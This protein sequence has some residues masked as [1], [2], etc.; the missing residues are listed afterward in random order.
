VRSYNDSIVVDNGILYS[1]SANLLGSQLIKQNIFR[2]Y[3][4]YGNYTIA[5][6][7]SAPLAVSIVENGVVVYTTSGSTISYRSTLTEN[8]PLSVTVQNAETSVTTYDVTI[9]FPNVTV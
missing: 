9:D 4:L 5:I 1:C 2:S 7:A 6:N 8:E 3:Q